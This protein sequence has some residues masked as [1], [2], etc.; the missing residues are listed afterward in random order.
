MAMKVAGAA[1]AISLAC[2]A[3]FMIKGESHSGESQ[4]ESSTDELI[5]ALNKLKLSDSKVFDEV[6]FSVHRNGEESC[7]S[8]PSSL[9]DIQ[10]SLANFGCSS[11][12]D[13]FTME[14]FLTDL[15]ASALNEK[16]CSPT[17]DPSAPPDFYHY[18]DMGRDRTVIQL[19]HDKLVR[20][21]QDTLPCRFFTREGVRISSIK[22][23]NE[24]A[25][26]AK[27]PKDCEGDESK[28]TCAAGPI[29][30]LYAV[31]A[32]RVF[33]FA[34]KFVGE[35]FETSHVRDGQNRPI[36]LE[37]ISTNPRVFD[38]HNFFSVD[39]A[40]GL[41]D[42]AL[43]ETSPTYALHRSTTGSTSTSVFNKRTSENAWDTH[44]QIASEIKR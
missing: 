6:I 9:N 36:S 3:I 1:L 38:V 37:V 25:G 34:P 41:I 12:L 10:K 17:D 19:D 32:G 43:K 2:L 44:G 26:K 15:L 40:K 14:S 27:L 33:M 31:P 21:S 22:Q 8:T 30:D 4:V 23:L 20:T 7:G 29:L 35:I 39:E 13:K 16:E 5:C 42:K 28:E 11:D 24:L 18:C